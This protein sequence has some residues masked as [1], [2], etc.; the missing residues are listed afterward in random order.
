VLAT[1]LHMTCVQATIVA[2]WLIYLDEYHSYFYRLS[3]LESPFL[4]VEVY[5]AH[6]VSFPVYTIHARTERESI[7]C[8]ELMLVTLTLALILIVIMRKPRLLYLK[9]RKRCS[10]RRRTYLLCRR[11]DRALTSSYPLLYKHRTHQPTDSE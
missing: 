3:S 9:R 10:L 6:T 8:S 11:R 2:V 7:K 4:Y 5:L 1:D